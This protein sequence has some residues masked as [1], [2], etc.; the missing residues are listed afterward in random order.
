M[1]AHPASSISYRGRLQNEDTEREHFVYIFFSLQFKVCLTESHPGNPSLGFSQHMK[2][3][4]SVTSLGSKTLVYMD[5][6]GKNKTL[7]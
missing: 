7:K 2:G 6:F 3:S 4:F 1:L 5:L